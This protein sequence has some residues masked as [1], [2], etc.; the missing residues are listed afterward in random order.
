VTQAGGARVPARYLLQ[1]IL[2]V[3]NE[4]GSTLGLDVH[5]A[6]LLERVH[7]LRVDLFHR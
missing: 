1:D 5:L 2:F 7:A 4:E 3:D 6:H